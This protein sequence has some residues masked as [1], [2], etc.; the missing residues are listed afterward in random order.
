MS[1]RHRSD[2]RCRLDPNA[3]TLNSDERCANA[4]ASAGTSCTAPPTA[5]SWKK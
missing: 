4:V 2:V 1:S 3:T 5:R